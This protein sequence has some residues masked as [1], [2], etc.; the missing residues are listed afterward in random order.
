MIAGLLESLYLEVVF[1]SFSLLH[2]KE[3]MRVLV[4]APIGKKRHL[5]QITS[6]IPPSYR[7]AIYD[8]FWHIFYIFL[9]MCVHGAKHSVTLN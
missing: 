3:P 9:A 4:T 8:F 1:I 2:T 6:P 7:L 5:V